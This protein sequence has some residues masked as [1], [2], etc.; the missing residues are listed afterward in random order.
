MALGALCGCTSAV[1]DPVDGSVMGKCYGGL[2]NSF[3]IV[4]SPKGSVVVGGTG[5]IPAIGSGIG[6]AAVSATR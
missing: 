3:C 4:A 1:L 2:F 6:V 5:V